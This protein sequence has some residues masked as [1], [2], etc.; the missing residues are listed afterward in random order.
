[1]ISRALATAVCSLF[2]A[3]CMAIPLTTAVRLSAMD[4]QSL[5]S[6]DP[7]QLRVRV[8]VPTGFGLDIKTTQLQLV[9]T[10]DVGQR[11]SYSYRLVL[12]RM[13]NDVRS[14]GMFH[15]KYAVVAYELALD[16]ESISSIG[17]LQKTVPLDKNPRLALSVSSSFASSPPDAKFVR[18]WVDLKLRKS[19]AYFV[20]LDGAELQFN[21]NP[22]GS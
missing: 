18:F 20:L 5:L 8:A 6:L 17:G 7:E 1:M 14:S 22:K 13:V 9:L 15:S 11:R 21:R 4:Q 10:N 19:E 16:S 2:I 3:G 12:L